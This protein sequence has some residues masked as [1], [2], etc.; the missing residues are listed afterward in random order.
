MEFEQPAIIAEGLAEAAVHE[1]WIGPLMLPAEKLA[2]GSSEPGKSLTEL[3]K[4]IEAD[5]A[6][7]NATHYEIAPHFRAGIMKRGLD[8]MINYA[9]QYKV[10]QSEIGARMAEIIE[11]SG[12]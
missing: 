8:L 4:E 5:E 12:L 7:K 11:V 6:V 9:S 3:V 10:T 2:A 1:P